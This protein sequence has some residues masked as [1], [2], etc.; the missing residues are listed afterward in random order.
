MF[1]VRDATFD[2]VAFLAANNRAMALET[3]DKG[4]ELA[5]VTRGIQ[6][7]LD[8]DA[9][10]RYW[11][12]ERDGE[13]IAQAMVTYEWTDW[14]DGRVWWIQSVYVVPKARRVGAFRAL[15]AHIRTE[16]E[17]DPDGRGLRLYVER[18]NKAAKA[19]YEAMGMTTCVYDMYEEMF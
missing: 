12:L 10:G 1:S 14:R 2:D 13:S 15:Y 11:I 16:A 19:T 17:H 9:R 18:D 3:E 7:L 4:L 8:D 6:R 5:Q